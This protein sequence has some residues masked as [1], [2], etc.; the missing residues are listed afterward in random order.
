MKKII[1]LL[2]SVGLFLLS[3]WMLLYNPN[4]TDGARVFVMLSVTIFG[5]L[6]LLLLVMIFDDD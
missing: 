5:F 1:A 2:I 6:T 3:G 4:V